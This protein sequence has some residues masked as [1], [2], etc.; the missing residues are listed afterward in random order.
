MHSRRKT[1]KNIIFI[2]QRSLSLITLALGYY[3]LISLCAVHYHPSLTKTSTRR[4]V[5]TTSTK[6]LLWT[7]KIKSKK[8]RSIP[9]PSPTLKRSSTIFQKM[10]TQGPPSSRPCLIRLITI[11]SESQEPWKIKES[12]RFSKKGEKPIEDIGTDGTHFKNN[13]IKNKKVSVAMKT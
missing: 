3:H 7:I 13:K 10:Q 4:K 6:Y 2:I 12:D 5:L 1:R 11:S 8:L 9:S